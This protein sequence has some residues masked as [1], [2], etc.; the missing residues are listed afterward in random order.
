[1]GENDDIT[2]SDAWKRGEDRWRRQRSEVIP[3][4]EKQRDDL[5]ARIDAGEWDPTGKYVEEGGSR[6]YT[7]SGGLNFTS[8]MLARLQDAEA[9]DENGQASP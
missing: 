9:A 1:M 6:F 2:Q 7:G 3:Q 8:A 4:L 5:Q